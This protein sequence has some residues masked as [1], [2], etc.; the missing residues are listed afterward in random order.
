M[1]DHEK[2]LLSNALH[3]R[4]RDVGDDQPIDLAAVRG[5][6]HGIRR[7]R[8]LA[9]GLAVAAAVAVTVPLG[10]STVGTS[11]SSVGP[12]GQHTATST[13]S[14][15]TTRST[16]PAPST[17]VPVVPSELPQGDPPTVPWLEGRTLHHDGT[18]TELPPGRWSDV[19]AYRGG[20]L[21]VQESNR[22]NRLV[23]ID[24]GGAV[25]S[26]KPGGVRIDTSADG[27]QLA[28]VEDGVLHRG[29]ASGHSEGEDTQTVP[30][31]YDAQ[32]AGFASA[33][34][35]V[36]TLTGTTDAN[37][38]DQTV[39]VTDFTD[40]RTVPGLVHA[41]SSNDEAGLVAGTTRFDANT[42]G[43]CFAMVFPSGEQLWSDC[44]HSVDTLSPAGRFVTGQSS[45]CD[46]Q[47]G[48]GELLVRQARTGQPAVEFAAPRRAD[49]TSFGIV[50]WEDE[51]HMLG[52]A[53]T[54]PTGE[55]WLVRFGVDG[56]VERVAGP[57][58]GVEYEPAFAL[59]TS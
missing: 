17:T 52:V 48:C 46:Q 1:S 2:D 10:L 19:A 15:D 44:R 21:A 6:A 14:P 13:P 31:G 26:D 8:R 35:V 32:V 57:V 56:S 28:W 4:A 12:T 54:Y 38:G 34:S 53:Y 23:R 25:T 7:R 59:P 42:G 39:H 37:A 29:L 27:T 30:K 40:D 58:K 11:P 22:G 55:W 51:E 16:A 45:G 36:Y 41:R 50:G 9:A 5:R 20:W 33:G 18:T 3:D 49:G 24:A 43:A 47:Y